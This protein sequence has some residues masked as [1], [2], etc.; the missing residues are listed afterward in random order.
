MSWNRTAQQAEKAVRCVGAYDSSDRWIDKSCF[1]SYQA[2]GS[3]CN[4]R[5]LEAK[6]VGTERKKDGEGGERRQEKKSGFKESV[7]GGMG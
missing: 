3:P 1:K 6:M 7:E 2:I 4:P 5:M